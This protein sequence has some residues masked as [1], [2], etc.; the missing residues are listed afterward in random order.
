MDPFLGPWIIDDWQKTQEVPK[1]IP[2]N[3]FKKLGPLNITQPD[4]N[5]NS[6]HL[7]WLN[8]DDQECWVSDL[9]YDEVNKQLKGTDR[10]ANFASVPVRCDFLVGELPPNALGQK[11]LSLQINSAGNSVTESA[12]HIHPTVLPEVGSGVVTATANPGGG[13]FARKPRKP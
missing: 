9:Q 6:V 12:I 13:G 4:P 10:Q 3:G 2:G 1:G 5:I 7:Q 8:E 11:R